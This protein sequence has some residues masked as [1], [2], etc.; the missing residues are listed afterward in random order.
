M[1]GRIVV[2]PADLLEVGDVFSTDGYVVSAVVI[3]PKTRRVFVQAALD[4]DVKTAARTW[5]QP[6]PVWVEGGAA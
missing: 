2:K 4:G 5:D 1:M 6:L 3:L